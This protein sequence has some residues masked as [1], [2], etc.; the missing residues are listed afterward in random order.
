MRKHRCGDCTDIQF[1]REH[2][3]Y[4]SHD[5]NMN[6]L[7]DMRSSKTRQ[8]RISSFR[9]VVSATIACRPVCRYR[10]SDALKRISLARFLLGGNNSL[11]PNKNALLREVY[12]NLRQLIFSNYLWF[13]VCLDFI[14]LCTVL[15][16][17]PLV[18][19]CF[20]PLNSYALLLYGDPLWDTHE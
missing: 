2:A 17:C 10:L 7:V 13:S 19:R 9:K 16:D 15:N 14:S 12:R 11:C 8:L 18:L 4:H 6:R 1:L 20:L 5:T 3:G